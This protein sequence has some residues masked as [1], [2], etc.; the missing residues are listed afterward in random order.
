MATKRSALGKGL[1]AL[2]PGMNGI[3]NTEPA[4]PQKET[5]VKQQVDTTIASISELPIDKIVPNPYQP[6]TNF[7][8][9]ALAELS[10]SIQRLGIIQPITVRKVGNRYQIISGE[11]RFKASQLAGLKTIPA[12]IKETDDNGMLQMAIVENIQREDLDAIEVAL[13][14]QRL[15]DECKLTQESMAEIVGKKRTTITNYLRLLKL[16]AE[17]Q[18]SIRDKEITMGHAKAILSLPKPEAQKNLCEQILKKGL[19]VRQ[20]EAK[21][22]QLLKEKPAEEKTKPTDNIPE[23]Y[24]KVAEIVGKYFDNN[25]RFK[26]NE[27]GKGSITINFN[28]DNEVE[29][30]LRAIEQIKN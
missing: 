10:D 28:N 26:R 15:I 18:V 21:A 13:S 6:R 22:Q 29:S 9:T 27:K 30:F 16:P 14:F 7:E 19:S 17:I 2:I 8:E 23:S 12:Y 5:P 20:A 4:A 3:G 1:G 11:R 25:I 24:Y